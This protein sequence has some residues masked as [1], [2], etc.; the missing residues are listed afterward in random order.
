MAA[1]VTVPEAGYV[2]PGRWLGA[3]SLP[4]SLG[5]EERLARL[6]GEGNERAFAALYE[7]YHQPLYRYCRSL[8]RS[9]VDAQDALQSTFTAALS[10]LRRG[11]RDA[12]LRP[13]LFRIAHNES[14][15]LLRRRRPEAALSEATESTVPSAEHSAEDR[16]R[17]ASL[18]GDLSD[19]P[20]RQRGALVMRELSGLSHEQIAEAFG[21]SV[22]AAKQTIFEARRS[23]AE[24]AEGRIMACEEIQ[25]VVSDGDGRARRSRRVRAHLRDC[26]RCAAFATAISRREADLRALSP[27]LPVAAAAGI[28]V[29]VTGA[30]SGHSGGA[31][32]LAAGA[33]SKAATTVV[34]LKAATAGVAVVTAAVAG[35]AGVLHGSPAH[36]ARSSVSGH[37]G[38]TPGQVSGAS[39]RSGTSGGGAPATGGASARL[40]L[41]SSG[42]PTAARNT[43]AVGNPRSHSAAGNGSAIRGK[44]ATAP[45][46]GGAARGAG[47]HKGTTGNHGTAGNRGASGNHGAA[48]SGSAGKHLGA[49]KLPH[50]GK[51]VGATTHTAG[52]TSHS[53]TSHAQGSTS[54][55]QEPAVA[56]TTAAA[57]GSDQSP[58]GQTKSPASSSGSSSASTSTA[59]ASGPPATTKGQPQAPGSGNGTKK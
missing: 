38:A 14:I 37:V 41:G 10:A 35:T 52:S 40:T 24:F 27:V 46:H 43:G 15:S 3:P 2:R 36:H 29:R 44:S 56:T 25:R 28:L 16:A 22:G 4:L 5:G 1:R 9:D 34:S 39:G 21:I 47:R 55:S 6:A 51:H 23:L 49:T 33:T 19:L 17:L 20:E 57:H 50:P 7:R 45:G 42:T 13:W 30:G 11:R 18:V 58:A 54:H 31:G 32:G 12:P 53:G 59:S 26:T 48:S 8:V